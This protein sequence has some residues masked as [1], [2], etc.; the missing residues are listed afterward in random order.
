MD[1]KLKTVI[2]VG[3]GVLLLAGAIGI[4]AYRNMSY[5]MLNENF[6]EKRVS[7]WDLPKISQNYTTARK[8]IIS[9]ARTMALA[10]SC[11]TDSR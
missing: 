5:D 10:S 6:L 3:T 7:N 2:A 11:F 1:K 8:F 9:K 4:F